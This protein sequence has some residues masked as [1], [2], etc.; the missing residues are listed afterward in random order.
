M[1][2]RINIEKAQ[3]GFIV[4]TDAGDKRIAVSVSDLKNQIESLLA[5][6]KEQDKEIW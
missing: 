2:E 4:T 3:N 5:S 1:I 6:D